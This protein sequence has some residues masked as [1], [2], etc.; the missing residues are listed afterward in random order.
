MPG[1]YVWKNIQGWVSLPVGAP[2]GNLRGGSVYWKLGELAEGGFCLWSN[3]L[4]GSSVRE[5]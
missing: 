3:S 2:L 4:Y 1:A 5:T